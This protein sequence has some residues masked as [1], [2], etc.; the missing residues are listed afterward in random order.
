MI[1]PTL[2]AEPSHSL[3]N[4]PSSDVAA[5]RFL[6]RQLLGTSDHNF[7]IHPGFHEC[8]EFLLGS[9]SRVRAVSARKGPPKFLKFR[10]LI[11]SRRL[12]DRPR[13]LF[14]FLL[15]PSSFLLHLQRIFGRAGGGLGEHWGS[16][17]LYGDGAT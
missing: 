14:N 5:A 9:L 15:L 11:W 1:G 8:V 3:R 16:R 7:R 13:V 4:E 2:L 17:A 6:H 10:I 12:G